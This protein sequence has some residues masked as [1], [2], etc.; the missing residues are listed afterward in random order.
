MMNLINDD[1]CLFQ[2][3]INVENPPPSTLRRLKRAR[4]VREDLYEKVD[5]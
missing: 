3:N 1:L 4:F 5:F 2:S